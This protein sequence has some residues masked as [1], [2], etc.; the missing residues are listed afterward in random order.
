MSPNAKL[1]T[2]RIVMSV[3]AIGT[4]VLPFLADWN[5]THIY[6]PEWPPHAKFHNA[7][8]MSIAVLLGIAGLA[9]LWRDTDRTR[10]G[11]SA[12]WVMIALYW[13]S[14]GLAFLFPGVAW[15]DPHLL[16][17]GQSLDQFPLQLKGDVVLIP[18][19]AA[20]GWLLWSGSG[21]RPRP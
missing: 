18:V 1:L 4:V 3:I 8:T 21:H 11:L 20:A 17:P 19:M 12:G 14:Q 9:F 10:V 15:T 2:G 5:E 6:N 7:Q 13:V 16:Q